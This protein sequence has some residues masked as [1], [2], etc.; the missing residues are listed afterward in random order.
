M[1]KY[2]K[3][4][5]RVFSANDIREFQANAGSASCTENSGTTCGT[6]VTVCI[7]VSFCFV[8]K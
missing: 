3:P 8:K 4:Q 5:M 7:C 1:V 2:S 6:Q